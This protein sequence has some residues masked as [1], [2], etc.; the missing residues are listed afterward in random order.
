MYR[1]VD[2]TG[3][4]VYSQQRPSGAAV[5]TIKPDP[6]PSAEQS[7]QALDRLRGQ[8][9]QGVDKRDDQTRTTEEGEKNA[10]E[11]AARKANC[12]AARQNLDT[13]QN[14]GRG[15]LRTPDG[16]TT[17]LSKDDLA[18]HIDEARQQIKDNCN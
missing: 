2:E 1:W 13:L 9:E 5:T 8:V 16:K 18:K 6:A 10:A 7:Q 3:T 12:E 4:T 17:Y 15:R 14:R 11:Q